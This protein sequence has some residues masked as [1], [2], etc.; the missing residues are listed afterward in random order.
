MTTM[1]EQSIEEFI[2]T[3]NRLHKAICRELREDDRLD[4]TVAVARYEDKRKSWPFGTDLRMLAR[5]RNVL[6][7][8]QRHPKQYLAHPS[9]G[10]L[11]TL[12]RVLN[13]VE[14]PTLLI[15]RFQR[16]V[17]CV[18]V[19]DALSDILPRVLAGSFSQ[20]PV[21]DDDEFKGL[22]TENGIVRYL[23]HHQTSQDS[24]IELAEVSV[25]AL[26]RQ[27]ENRK[28]VAFAPRTER[29][30]AMLDRFAQQPVLE[31]VLITAKGKKEEKLLGIATQWDAL[32]ARKELRP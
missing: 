5:L 4:F 19:D 9:K 25:R 13:S 32:K 21:Y 12:Q 29:L 31:A 7:H 18:G 8:E 30:D 14:K 3:F 11:Q 10:S 2:T 28:N 22:L 16:T 26:L 24:L 15:P 23:A 6:V 20:F 17:E 1:T 27:D